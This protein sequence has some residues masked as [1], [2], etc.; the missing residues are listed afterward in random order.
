MQLIWHR[1][2]LRTHDHPALAA[3]ARSG[4][5][6]GIV[7][8]DPRLLDA[9]SVRRRA[10]HFASVRALRTSYEALGGMLLVRQGAPWDVLPQL[11]RA[12]GASDVHALRSHSPYGR[13]R[14]ERT[15]AA[16]AA[17]GIELTWHDGRYVRAPGTIHTRTGTP[18]TVFGPYLRAWREAGAP[19][20]LEAPE[21]IEPPV[22]GG[23][24]PGT[25]PDVA[26]DVPLP[27]AGEAAA[28]AAFREFVE[29]RASTYAT[30]RDRLDGTGGSRLSIYLALGVLSART[31]A[32][33]LWE[34]RGPGPQKWLEELA[35]RDF[36]VDLLHHRP[37]L[38][39][40]S[41]R[42]RW[43]RFDWNRSEADFT[44]WQ[45]GRTGFPVV[46]AA[47]RELRATGWISNRARMIS[48]QFLCKHLRVDWRRGARVFEEWLLDADLASNI[49]NWQWAAGVGID[50]APYFRLFNPVTQGK[51]HD[52]EGAWLRRWVPESNGDPRALPGAIVDLAEARHAYLAA[53]EEIA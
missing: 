27:A 46:D 18:F 11:G 40:Q 35:W 44:A 38:V 5:I 14:D 21:Q 47:L 33:T 31:A 19:A 34:R 22:L 45:E 48:A 4:P 43:D 50:N 41:F 7:V 39:E 1:R 16:L 32:A 28:L 51:S 10:L 13:M 8:F 17:L 30:L 37:T 49:G 36:L 53:A 25:V 15:E 24:Q 12:L 29:R 23:V 20:P 6:A 52:P 42:P 26:S 9:T 2:D 3:A